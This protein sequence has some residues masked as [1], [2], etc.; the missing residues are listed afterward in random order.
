MAAVLGEFFQ[1]FV[2]FPKFEE[3]IFLNV[4]F[5]FFH[6]T[7]KKLLVFKFRDSTKVEKK[8]NPIATAAIFVS[9][10]R[11]NN[12]RGGG[13]NHSVSHDLKHKSIQW[14]LLMCYV[15]KLNLNS[16]PSQI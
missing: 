14:S 11:P 3:H 9:T 16:S 1:T 10:P 5:D 4:Y 7:E 2:R 8:K 6:P 15:K 12:K 13:G